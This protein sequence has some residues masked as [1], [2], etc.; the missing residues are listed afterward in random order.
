MKA[1]DKSPHRR[2]RRD[3]LPNPGEI[4]A[5]SK[6]Y[7]TSFER[8]LGAIE[9]TPVPSLNVVKS[10][11]RRSIENL[12]PLLGEFG[13]WAVDATAKELHARLTLPDPQF[14]EEVLSLRS[15]L[16]S[17]LDKA[18]EAVRPLKRIAL[19]KQRLREALRHLDDLIA[20][21]GGSSTAHALGT[22]SCAL[23]QVGEDPKRCTEALSSLDELP[24]LRETVAH[25][26]KDRRGSKG[27]PFE[28]AFILGLAEIWQKRTGSRPP[29]VVKEAKM[30]RSIGYLFYPFVERA[31]SDIGQPSRGLMKRIRRVLDAR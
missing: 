24:R 5:W 12:P 20:L 11:R 8:R 28:D 23:G 30:R 17:A 7:W 9:L 4:A 16:W 13:T 6:T 31:F 10:F 27:T 15:Q 14:G 18:N 1:K 2:S 21:L 26:A 22:L 3:R 29:K 25:A 19:A